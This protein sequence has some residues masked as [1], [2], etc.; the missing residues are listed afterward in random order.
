LARSDTEESKI[1]WSGFNAETL[2]PDEDIWEATAFEFI[3]RDDDE[4]ITGL[5]SLQGNLVVF[6]KN[7]TYYITGALEPNQYAITKV[8]ELIGC[9]SHKSIVPINN[10]IF[11]MSYRGPAFLQG[12]TIR[13]LSQH[14]IEDIVNK[15]NFNS[16]DLITATLVPKYNEVQVAI[17]YNSLTNNKIL[18]WNYAFYNPQKG[19]S[20]FYMFNRD[21]T[22]LRT[23]FDDNNVSNLDVNNFLYYS[24]SYDGQ[25]LDED[26]FVGSDNGTIP[27]EAYLTTKDI[28]FGNWHQK[29]RQ[30]ITDLIG[31]GRIKLEVDTGS[32][33]VHIDYHQ[34]STIQDYWK[35]SMNSVQGTYAAFKFICN[36]LGAYVRIYNLS[37]KIKEHKIR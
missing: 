30:V 20:S 16:A 5:A 2:S 26:S 17:P 8:D 21:V 37:V 15:I 33:F 25:L 34:L 11:F 10:G 24:G 35:Q 1:Q 22:I 7:S 28:N 12:N 9:C 23:I 27:I 29:W 18:V 31:Q 4:P 6:K 36:D 19:E 3:N 32:G 13:I 14:I